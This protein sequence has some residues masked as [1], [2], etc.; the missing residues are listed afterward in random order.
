MTPRQGIPDEIEVTISFNSTCEDATCMCTVEERRPRYKWWKCEAGFSESG[1]EVSSEIFNSTEGDYC[2]DIRT[3][4]Y[5]VSQVCLRYDQCRGENGYTE[6]T[7]GDCCVMGGIGYLCVPGGDYSIG[8]DGCDCSWWKHHT[9]HCTGRYCCPLISTTECT[10]TPVGGSYTAPC[11]GYQCSV[12]QAGPC[13]CHSS[14]LDNPIRTASYRCFDSVTSTDYFFGSC[15]LHYEASFQG[16]KLYFPS[17][18]NSS[19]MLN[20]VNNPLKEIPFFMLGQGPSFSDYLDAVGMCKP[21]RVYMNEIT[22][23][24]PVFDYNELNVSLGT[25]VCFRSESDARTLIIDNGARVLEQI[26]DACIA[27]FTLGQHTVVESETGDSLIIRVSNIASIY[28][29]E[30]DL[31]PSKVM[32]P[33]G[34]GLS[35]NNT[36]SRFHRFRLWYDEYPTYDPNNPGFPTPDVDFSLGPGV[37]TYLPLPEEGPY[38]LADDTLNNIS[39]A[40]FLLSANNFISTDGTSMAP[41]E[42]AVATGQQIC[43]TCPAAINHELAIY[44]R[45]GID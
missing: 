39:S 4:G 15:K 23:G 18:C 10:C 45:F 3:A 40:I 44:K 9:V 33:R 43:F 35:L 31:T 19:E 25:S 24:R 17:P 16:G 11:W 7:C 28:A 26:K 8:E 38:L 32:V 37:A 2:Y 36:D 13:S 14:C 21:E 42:I 34:S 41:A 12:I 30:D 29:T 5:G 1:A 22:L 20:I 6:Y 27:N